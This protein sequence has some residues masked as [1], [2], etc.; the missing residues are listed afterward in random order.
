[1]HQLSGARPAVRNAIS[2]RRPPADRPP[3]GDGQTA[4]GLLT[5]D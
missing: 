3:T 4:D 1:M 2:Y 5:D